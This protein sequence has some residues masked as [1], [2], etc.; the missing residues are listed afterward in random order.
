MIHLVPVQTSDPQILEGT[1][2]RLTND[3]QYKPRTEQTSD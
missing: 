2:L 3:G 1:N